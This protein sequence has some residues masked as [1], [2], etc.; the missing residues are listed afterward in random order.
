MRLQA[1]AT[2][3][4]SVIAERRGKVRLALFYA[5]EARRLAE[6]CGDQQTE[7]RLLNNLG[8]LSFLAGDA[9]PAV[10]YIKQSFALFL[11]IGNDADAAQAVSSLAQIHLRLGAPILAEEQARHALSILDGRDDYLEERGN[12]QLVLGRALLG[13]EHA[14]RRRWP[15]SRLRSA[16]SED[17]GRRATSPRPGRPKAMRTQ[18]LATRRPRQRCSGARPRPCRTSTSRKGGAFVRKRFDLYSVLFFLLTVAYFVAAA[19][20]LGHGQPGKGFFNGG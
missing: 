1:L 9:G 6:E 19:K 2:M 10:A 16:C 17:W 13:Q 15:S 11:E 18:S 12:A 4:C 8:G 20:G 14:P 7:A 3:Q 5:D